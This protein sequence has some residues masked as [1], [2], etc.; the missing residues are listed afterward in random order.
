MSSPWE[1]DVKRPSRLPMLFVLVALLVLTAAT[2]TY[3]DSGSCSGPKPHGDIRSLTYVGYPWDPWD[4]IPDLIEQKIWESEYIVR[5]QLQSVAASTEK[6]G[7]EHRPILRH[8]FTVHEWMKGTGSSS[9]VVILRPVSQPHE[10][11]WWPRY[12]SWHKN[13]ATAQQEAENMVLGRN[14]RWE[15]RQAI[16]LLSKET[17]EWYYERHKMSEVPT[18]QPDTFVF[19]TSQSR[20]RPYLDFSI[21][22]LHRVWLPA[23]G[24]FSGE[25]TRFLTGEWTTLADFRTLMASVADALASNVK[26]YSECYKSSLRDMHLEAERQKG[27]PGRKLSTPEDVEQ[28]DA[29]GEVELDETQSVLLPLTC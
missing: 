19:T 4:A 24:A 5:A 22:S 3:E 27:N 16:L 15:S 6:V 2:P 9:I 25:S 17:A 11:D 20:G 10:Q 18:G 1:A 29:T 13:A 12:W 26:G 28:F 14:T 21:D 8:N 7:D 23:E